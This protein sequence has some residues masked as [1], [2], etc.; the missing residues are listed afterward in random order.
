[1]MKRKRFQKD[2]VKYYEKQ[3]VKNFLPI[4]KFLEKHW[5]DSESHPT[6][7]VR[8]FIPELQSK[9][10]SKGNSNSRWFQY[11]NMKAA[12]DFAGNVSLGG[13]S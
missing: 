9:G 1:M 7:W 12:M 13:L 10:D 5:L 11:T 8:N 2:K 6:D 3:L 4:I